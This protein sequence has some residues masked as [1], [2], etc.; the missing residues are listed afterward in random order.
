M[1]HL[2]GQPTFGSGAKG[3]RQPARH[4]RRH[5][6]MAVQQ[7]G[8]LLSADAECPGRCGNRYVERLETEFEDYLAG[9]RWIMLHEI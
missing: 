9:M 4:I 8:Q 2:L 5:A 7:F 6:S 3:N 1:M